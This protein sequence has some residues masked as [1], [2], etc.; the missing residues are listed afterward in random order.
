MVDLANMQKVQSPILIATPVVESGIFDSMLGITSKIL[1]T[2]LRLIDE[3]INIYHFV[4][5]GFLPF[6]I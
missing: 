3:P 1:Q 4:E 6:S 2:Q 5:H